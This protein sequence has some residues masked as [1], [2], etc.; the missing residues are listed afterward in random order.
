MALCALVAGLVVGGA[1]LAID[2]SDDRAR[3]MG[4]GLQ[5]VATVPSIRPSILDP[6]VDAN[7]VVRFEHVPACADVLGM[8]CGPFLATTRLEDLETSVRR[9]RIEI[10][11]ARKNGNG[12]TTFLALES[13][14]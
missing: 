5:P 7:G 9:V 3:Q 8:R 14:S 10:D 2:D 11:P 1:W 12:A 6:F 4:D 13:G